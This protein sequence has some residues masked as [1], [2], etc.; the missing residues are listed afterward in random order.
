MRLSD[1]NEVHQ[2]K[3]CFRVKCYRVKCYR[4]KCYIGWNVTEGEM[5]QGETLQGEML[6]GEMSLGWNV[7]HPFYT[8]IWELRNWFLLAKNRLLFV[9]G[10]FSATGNGLESSLDRLDWTFGM[11]FHALEEKQP[12]FLVQDRIRRPTCVASDILLDVST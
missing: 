3:I 6:Q 9:S 8:K 5:L 10:S 7:I 1:A 4:E 12:G 2:K 11:A